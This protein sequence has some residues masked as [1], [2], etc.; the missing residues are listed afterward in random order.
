MVVLAYHP[1][2]W[3]SWMEDQE[4]KASLHHGKVSSN[5]ATC[6]YISNKQSLT[7]V[8]DQYRIKPVRFPAGV[9]RRS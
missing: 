1:S 3:D 9:R 4:F 5:W 6:K 2:T 8:P 7:A